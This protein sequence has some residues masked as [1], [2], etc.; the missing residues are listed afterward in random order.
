MLL[1][2]DRNAL[3]SLDTRWIGMLRDGQE[4]LRLARAAADLAA[5]ASP[6]ASL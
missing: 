1:L 4:L 2:A 6:V 5:E 3:T